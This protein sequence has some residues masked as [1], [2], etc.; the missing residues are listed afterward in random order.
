[1]GSFKII[2]MRFLCLFD[3]PK[4]KFVLTNRYIIR[5]GVKLYRI[6]C[7][8]SFGPFKK[9]ELGGYVEREDNLSQFGNAWVYDDACVFGHARVYNNA[10]ACG[11]VCISGNAEVYGNA[12]LC[13]DAKVYGNAKIHGKANIQDNAKVFDYADVFGNSTVSGNAKVF[14]NAFISGGAIIYERATVGGYALVSD[15][16]KVFGDACISGYSTILRNVSICGEAYISGYA[17]I[18]D[19]SQHCGF[20]CRIFNEKHVHAYMTKYKKIEI[21]CG[22]FCGDI[23][24]FEKI[25][26]GTGDE[27][28]CQAIIAIIKARFGLDG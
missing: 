14:G 16:S 10:I 27:N 9:G 17:F 4:K 15:E 8:K 26:K 1:M 22:L 28:E 24:A 12:F 25:A 18:E 5:D 19:D 23:E 7:I 6:K 11:N 2:M 21:T 13:N 3:K 20:N